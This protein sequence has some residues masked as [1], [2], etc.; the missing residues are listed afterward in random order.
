MSR[1]HIPHALR[2]RVSARAGDRCGYCLA[3]ERCGISIEIDH[4]IPVVEGGATSEENLWLACRDCNG[5]KGGRSRACDPVS[6]RE[7]AL[8]DPRR[9]VWGEH[10]AWSAEGDRITGLSATGRA[11]VQALGLNSEK[12]VLARRL[13]VAAGWHPP[14]E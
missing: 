11:T 7:V 2:E 3:N 6:G 8:F 13:W 12:R 5:H 1:P 4:I 14:I 10:F 9:Q